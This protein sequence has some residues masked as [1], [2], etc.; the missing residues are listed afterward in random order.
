MDMRIRPAATHWLQQI[1]IRHIRRSDLP[2]LEWDGVYQHFRRVYADAYS[3]YE[4]GQS[5]L[6]VAELPGAGIIGQVFIQLVCDR[7]E[8]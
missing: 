1:H 7:H 6:W 5:I 4:K 2:A 8:L 3:R